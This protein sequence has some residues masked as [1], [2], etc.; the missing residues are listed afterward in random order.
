[1]LIAPLLLLTAV[2]VATH[3]S[4]K[5]MIGSV[6][7]LTLI[8]LVGI[9]KHGTVHPGILGLT[10]L[11]FAGLMGLLPRRRFAIT[12][13]DTAALIVLAGCSLSV[14]TGHQTHTN[15]EIVFFLW[16]CPYFA[17]RSL[18]GSGQR[19]TVLKAFAIA[20]AVAIPFGLI[21]ITYGNLFLKVFRFGSDPKAGLGVPN[22]RL[23]IN[24]AEGALGQPIPYAM[25]LAIAAVAA[26]VL[27]VIRD[28]R[29]D[30]RWLYIGLG[31]IA[32]Q[33]T[34]L[35]RTSWLMLGVVA[36]LLLALNYSAVI[37]RRNM[38][39]VALAIVGAFV[40]LSVP[41]TN[42][43]ILGGTGKESVKLGKSADY[44]TLLLEQAL[45]PGYIPPLGTTEPQ[46]GPRDSKSIDDEYIHAAW[47]WGYLPIVGFVLMFVAFARGLWKQRR[48]IVP[49]AV[50]STCIATMIAL[51][52]VAFL[53]QQQVLVWLLWGCASGLAVGPARPKRVPIPFASRLRSVDAPVSRRP[54][55][56]VPV[57]V[58]TA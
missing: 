32:I 11:A 28:N 23:G 25:F 2:W 7:V 56:G 57:R 47:T 9:P 17:A 18:T 54:A 6:L 5:F 50:Y 40:V 29:R 51:E 53:T 52:G 38:R 42:Q 31:I 4:R 13:M 21:E 46:I 35:T 8:P 22:H 37:N 12:M 30:H 33:A 45:K 16:F 41:K 14:A 15:L 48:D 27:W 26:I 44:R 43:L 10:L 36:F 58:P 3:Y 39:L 49:L 20:G 19:T 34:A 1:M 24:R 55:D